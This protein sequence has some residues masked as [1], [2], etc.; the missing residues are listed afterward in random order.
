MNLANNGTLTLGTGSI[1][2]PSITPRLN[3][4]TN[5]TGT[6]HVV[7]SGKDYFGSDSSNGVC[8]MLGKNQTNLRY[9][10]IADSANT[11]STSGGMRM[12][13]DSSGAS[14]ID[15]KSLNGATNKDFNLYGNVVYLNG[16]S[17]MNIGCGTGSLLVSATNG[18]KL[19][20]ASEMTNNLQPCISVQRSS[21][22]SN[23]TGDGTTWVM[24]C[25]S[26]NFDQ[27]GDYDTS[28][29]KF[30]APVNGRYLCT[31]SIWTYGYNGSHNASSA[32]FY[33]GT[34]QYSGYDVNPANVRDNSAYMHLSFSRIIN[35]TAGAYLQVR[36]GVGGSTKTVS[37]DGG[38]TCC[39]LC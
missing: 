35:L 11:S 37:A 4:N 20:G 23:I 12:W 33:D 7:L 22:V 25:N 32:Q 16:F 14:N 38:W 36:L 28:T 27:G 2:A 3:L 5:T 31:A 13:V 39:L 10:T 26:E 34:N 18:F 6:A 21:A 19:S 9:L 8:L 1:S 30:T 29:Y 15:A 24:T 17:G